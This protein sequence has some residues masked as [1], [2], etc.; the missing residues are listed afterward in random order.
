MAYHHH[1]C[2]IEFSDNSFPLLDSI[3]KDLPE[4]CRRPAE[5]FKRNLRAAAVTV[6]IP[7]QMAVA[8]VMRRAYE[9]FMIDEKISGH[10]K[11]H[12]RA[13]KRFDKAL[14]SEK[15]LDRHAEEVKH[16][17]EENLKNEEIRLAAS[18]LIRQCTVQLWSAL[19]VFASDMFVSLL[20]AKPDLALKLIANEK[21]KRLFQPK[22]VPFE[23][24]FEY[25]FN[26]TSSMGNLLSNYQPIDT[27]PSMKTIFGAILPNPEAISRVLSDRVLWLLFQQRHLIVHRRGIVDSSYLS[28]TGDK[29]SLGKEICISPTTLKKYMKCVIKAGAAIGDGVVTELG[30]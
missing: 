26:L 24:L 1:F 13:Q 14:R 3:I 6:T 23:T 8:S 12:E 30:C 29:A 21:T 22:G 19:E 11:A 15:N 16:I 5:A 27:V 4:H 9:F 18:E 28:A 10:P 7:H 20:N 17:L 25:Q 2:F